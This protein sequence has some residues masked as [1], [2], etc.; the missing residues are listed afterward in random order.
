MRDGGGSFVVPLGVESKSDGE[1][2][3]LWGVACARGGARGV[4]RWV[5][6]PECSPFGVSWPLG[7]ASSGDG[8]QLENGDIP[9]VCRGLD[10]RGEE[11]L[12]HIGV[13]FEGEE[14]SCATGS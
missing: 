10:G 9:V 1:A 8:A 7:E 3:G 12:L 5:G 13:C 6:C 2:V 11:G 4:W 14:N